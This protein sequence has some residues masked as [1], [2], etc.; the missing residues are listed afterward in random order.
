MLPEADALCFTLWLFRTTKKG[1]RE[2]ENE[3]AFS[4]L[5]SGRETPEPQLTFRLLALVLP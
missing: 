5:S 2:D 1:Y 4:H 3:V